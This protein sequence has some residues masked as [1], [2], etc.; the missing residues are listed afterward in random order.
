MRSNTFQTPHACRPVKQSH[1]QNIDHYQRHPGVPM[2][3]SSQIAPHVEQVGAYAITADQFHVVE[4][5]YGETL[6]LTDRDGGGVA[7]M[8]LTV[9]GDPRD[10]FSAPNTS[11]LNLGV[12]CTTGTVL[13]SY[14]YQKMMT[15]GADTVGGHSL[16]PTSITQSEVHDMAATS[17]CELLW[18]ASA[19]LGLTPAQT[20][21]PFQAFIHHGLNDSGVISEAE[22]RSSAGDYVEFVADMD[23]RAV[24][25]HNTALL[26]TARPAA[27]T[28]EVA[29]HRAAG[30]E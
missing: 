12:Y 21:F 6:R 14:F 2:P 20:P 26:R 13:Y 22:S 5:A 28:I 7:Q 30:K 17:G 15:I 10:R 3:S 19:E 11:V 1:D 16:L 27:S 4:I 8:I 29:L 18:R 25:V 24:I 9:A 23:L